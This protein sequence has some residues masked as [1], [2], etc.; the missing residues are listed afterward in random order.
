MRLELML[1]RQGVIF[2]RFEITKLLSQ[3][4]EL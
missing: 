1:L 3:M 4:A 2:F